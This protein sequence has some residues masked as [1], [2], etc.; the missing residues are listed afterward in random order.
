MHNIRFFYFAKQNLGS[1]VHVADAQSNQPQACRLH[2]YAARKAYFELERRGRTSLLAA[3][4]PEFSI[5]SVEYCVCRQSGAIRTILQSRIGFSYPG[6]RLGDAGFLTFI[7][8]RRLTVWA[9]RRAVFA[10]CNAKRQIPGNKFVTLLW[11]G[12]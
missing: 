10:F 11:L 7:M 5:F 1:E 9:L 3:N 2:A 8:F 12:L 4:G 6:S